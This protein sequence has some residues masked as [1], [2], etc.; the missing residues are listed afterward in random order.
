MSINSITT[1]ITGGQSAGYIDGWE[2]L[3]APAALTPTGS[4]ETDAAPITAFFT[5]VTGADGTLGVIL[6]DLQPGSALEVYS[7]TATNGLPIYPPAGQTING[8]AGDSPV[9]IEGKTLAKFRKTSATN[10]AAQYTAN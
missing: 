4:D 2:S 9:T 6:P 3:G 8:G 7:A 1:P 10:W 5:V